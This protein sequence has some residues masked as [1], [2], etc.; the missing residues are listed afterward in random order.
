ME[1]TKPIN[2]FAAQERKQSLVPFQYEP[3]PLAAF[4]VEVKITHCG[5]CHSDLHLIDDD[6]KFSKYP[7]VPGHE[8]VGTVSELGR[9]VKHLHIGQRVGI[10]WQRSAC[11]TCEFCMSGQHN[12][13]LKQAAT[14]LGNYGGFADRIRVD[15]RFAIPVPDAL[16]SET[17]APLLCGGITVFSPLIHF[18]VQPI[19]RVGIIGVGGLGHLAIQFARAF[20]CE[21][22]AFSHSPDKA[23][24]ARN[25]GVHRFVYSEDAASMKALS[26]H[27]D[28]IMNTANVEMDWQQ[29]L[30]LLR[31]NGKLCFVGVPSAPMEIPAFALVSSRK[32]VVGSPIGSPEEIRMM[33]DF[34]VRHRIGAMTEMRPMQEVNSA[35]TRVRQGLVRYRMVLTHL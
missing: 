32:S 33:F 19:H 2:A 5:V 9:E 35:L 22:T 13:C 11:M 7:M 10:G 27:F 20:G 1:K 31:P 16:S 14:C 12:L 3:S 28:F 25:F 18:G 21:V 17:A 24:E 4:D 8:I 23:P 29:Y 15:S 30:S 26:G 34:A 6:W